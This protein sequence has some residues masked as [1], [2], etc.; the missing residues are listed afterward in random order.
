MLSCW[1]NLFLVELRYSVREWSHSLIA[2]YF[3]LFLIIIIIIIIIVVNEFHSTHD[4]V[5]IP[6]H[7]FDTRVNEHVGSSYRTEPPIRNM[8]S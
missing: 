2:F 5:G 7:A 3:R 1:P 4:Y 8:G 6:A